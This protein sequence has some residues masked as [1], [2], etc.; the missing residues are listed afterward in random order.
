M[1][2]IHK[3]V[4]CHFGFIVEVYKSMVICTCE[5]ERKDICSS[6]YS[7][8]HTCHT[9]SRLSV[10]LNGAKCIDEHTK[11]VNSKSIGS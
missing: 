2:K 4:I 1:A 5:S 9:N 3:T 8:L 6:S 7:S 10:Q 11:C